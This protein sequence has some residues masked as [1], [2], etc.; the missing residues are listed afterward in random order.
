MDFR[1]AGYPVQTDNQTVE[2]LL[3]LRTFEDIMGSKAKTLLKGALPEI[4][5]QTN[6]KG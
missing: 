4:W 1:V 6:R 3:L 5:T 2:R